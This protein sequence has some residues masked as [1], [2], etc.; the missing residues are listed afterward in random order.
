M[1]QPEI[2]TDWDGAGFNDLDSR[3]LERGKNT[4]AAV[5]D[6]RGEAT[7][8][9]PHNP[10]GSLRYSPFSQDNKWRA[11][12]FRERKIGGSWLTN[13]EPNQGFN[14]LG[15][16]KEGDGPSDNPN[17]KDDE[18]MIEQSDFPF[19]VDLVEQGEPFS[20]I[21]VETAKPV[22]RRLRNLQPLSSPSGDNLVEDPGQLNAGWG[23]AL[24]SDNPGRQWLI[25][26]QFKRDGL[27][28]MTVTGFALAR[29]ADFG[30]SKRGKKD[31]EASE[32]TYK[33]MP[34]GYFSA[35][36]DGVYQQILKWIWVGG[37]GWTALGGLPKITGSTTA[38]AGPGAGE[39]SAVI[40]VP[41]GTGDPWEYM[42]QY[43]TDDGV[44]WGL[45]IEP[46]DV[47]VASGNVTVTAE[48]IPA[49]AKR[50]RVQVKGTNGS[51][52]YSP[53]ST[54]VTITS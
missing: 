49:G 14:L 32:L 11:D 37:A 28:I 44:T 41:T 43:S 26:R 8:I 52:A 15:A 47:V 24:S 22:V 13:T 9:S 3:Y 51:V 35:M 31:S 20:V 33:P 25:G 40:A 50:F 2:G 39:V 16:F 17:I 1:T 27:P 23:R 5:R 36:I 53:A 45:L 6:A 18:F 48:G 30:K 10:D 42:L 7:D 19:D 4:F 34:D 21:P 46:S 54:S 12:L 38:T 29:S